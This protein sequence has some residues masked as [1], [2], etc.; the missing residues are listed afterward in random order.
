MKMEEANLKLVPLADAP[1]WALDLEAEADLRRCGALKEFWYVACLSSELPAGK[2]ISRTLFGTPMVLFR[3]AEGAPVALL[4]RCLHR[5]ARLS[6]GDVF[7][8]KLGCSYHGWTYDRTGAC[9]EVPSL[10]PSQA[11]SR[12]NGEQL[13]RS[14]L[15]SRPCDVGR[16][17]RFPTIE[18]DGLVFVYPGD[19]GT[20]PRKQ[21]FRVP[22]F[23]DARWCVYFMVTRFTNGVTPLV[24][25]FMDVSHTSF[26][27]RGWFRKPS[28]REVP[29]TV[30][31]KD[32]AVHVTY[33][34]Q[35]D[36]LTGLGRIFN[37]R[38]LEMTHTDRFF[39]P[40]ITRVDYRFGEAGFA[41]NSQCTPIGPMDTIVY[42]AI[43][44]RLPWDLPGAAAAKAIRPIVEWYTKR[45]IQQDVEIMSVQRD[46]LTGSPGGGEFRSTEADLLHTDIEAYRSWLREG[47]RGEG[48]QDEERAI[49]FWV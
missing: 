45:V 35:K 17:R 37:P 46:G 21:P 26:V 11:A 15:S 30:R 5:N 20:P 18:Q 43:S 22:F 31:R 29:A 12:L 23:D 38:G 28:R 25:N 3:D 27:H 1:P 8:G 48:P 16:V 14:G 10:G 49:T 4:D 33:H 19:E 24:E 40:N 47:G 7:G 34:E 42:T 13:R 44:F 41:I 32:G 36:A 2:P 6:A 9:V 39:S